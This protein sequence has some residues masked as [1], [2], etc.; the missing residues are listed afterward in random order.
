[1]DRRDGVRRL[2]AV[3]PITRDSCRGKLDRVYGI[4][5]FLAPGDAPAEWLADI[6]SRGRA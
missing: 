3:S 6:E 5:V 1:M 4:G 2:P